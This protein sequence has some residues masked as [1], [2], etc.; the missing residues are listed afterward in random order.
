M[1]ANMSRRTEK[2]EGEIKP[3]PLHDSMAK[4]DEEL[5]EAEIF[6]KHQKADKL[7][8]Q[9]T[10]LQFDE[11]LRTEAEQLTKEQVAKNELKRRDDE[12]KKRA[13]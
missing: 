12:L 7:R 8:Q 11:D 10:S 5:S 9:L 2:F 1:R 6:G 3:G 4:T 13:S